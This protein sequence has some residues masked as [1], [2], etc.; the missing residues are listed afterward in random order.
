MAGR[1]PPRKKGP[2]T[3]MEE[4]RRVRLPRGEES[5]GLLLRMLEYVLALGHGVPWIRVRKEQVASY[6]HPS[7]GHIA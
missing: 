3:P 1:P 6:V 4:I 5:M 2:Q 7:S